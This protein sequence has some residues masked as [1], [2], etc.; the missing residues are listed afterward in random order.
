MLK[1]FLNVSPEIVT[2]QPYNKVFQKIKQTFRKIAKRII[3]FRQVLYLW[4]CYNST[5]KPLLT[6][7]SEQ[8]P[9]VNSGQSDP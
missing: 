4:C 2:S 3:F 7:T 5:V 6:T 1:R 9:P 8:R